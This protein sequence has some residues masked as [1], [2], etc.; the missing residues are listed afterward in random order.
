MTWC[1]P[2]NHFDFDH[3]PSPCWTEYS[4][5]GWF[6]PPE[7]PNYSRSD[8]AEPSVFLWSEPSH[9]LFQPPPPAS[10]SSVWTSRPGGWSKRWVWD[11]SILGRS[12]GSSW[13]YTG[14]RPGVPGDDRRARM[15]DWPECWAAGQRAAASGRRG[16]SSGGGRATSW[17]S[18]CSSPRL[19]NSV[20]SS[21]DSTLK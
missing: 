13:S 14:K 2:L 18:G 4:H 5:S 20:M 6:P 16:R 9:P 19:V 10:S 17:S 1:D 21:V 12:C 8:S 11:R 3:F 7:K 15:T